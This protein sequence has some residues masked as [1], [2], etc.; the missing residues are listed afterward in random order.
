MGVLCEFFDTQLH[1]FLNEH[2]NRGFAQFAGVGSG[3]IAIIGLY[4]FYKRLKNQDIQR[5]D[6]RFNSAIN[7]LGSSET[8]ARTGAMANLPQTEFPFNL[9]RQSSNFFFTT[10]PPP[11]QKYQLLHRLQPLTC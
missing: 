8:S 5:V 1:W 7:L 6:D 10:V 11:Y 4:F 3:L 2:V 9:P